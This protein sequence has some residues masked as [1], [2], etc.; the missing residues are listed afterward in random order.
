[1]QVKALGSRIRVTDCNELLEELEQQSSEVLVI[2]TLIEKYSKSRV[3]GSEV[4]VTEA[5]TLRKCIFQYQKEPQF[6]VAAS[7][8][9][10]TAVKA[11]EIEKQPQSTHPSKNTDDG[12][13]DLENDVDQAR[14]DDYAIEEED[15]YRTARR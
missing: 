4:V 5:Q 14:T 15:Y 12:I 3:A 10:A 1:M 13:S 7:L 6:K 11:Y 9:V 2:Y 8:E